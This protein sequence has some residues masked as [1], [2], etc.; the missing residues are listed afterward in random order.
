M[1]AELGQRVGFAGSPRLVS[2]LKLRQVFIAGW[3]RCSTAAALPQ[4]QRVNVGKCANLTFEECLAQHPSYCNWILSRGDALGPKYG[5]LLNFLR[6]QSQEIPEDLDVSSG[7]SVQSD[8]VE[9]ELSRNAPDPRDQNLLGFGKH[10][11]MTFAE[12]LAQHPDYCV[13]IQQSAKDEKAGDRLRAFGEYLEGKTFKSSKRRW[14]RSASNT[15]ATASSASTAFVETQPSRGVL[16]DGSWLIN[17]GKYRGSTFAE[18]FSKDPDYCEYITSS[19]L[20]AEQSKASRESL[21]F[22]NYILFRAYQESQ[23][24]NEAS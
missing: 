15:P 6:A 16:K 9:Q 7:I 10:K 19:V 13:W 12:V 3:R 1:R 5:E 14:G 4:G 24:V 17:F 18:V 8:F 22:A 21:A 11:D 20:S 23:E 2:M